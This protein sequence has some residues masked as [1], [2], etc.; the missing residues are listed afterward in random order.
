M[1]TFGLADILGSDEAKTASRHIDVVELWSGCFSVG[2]AALARG[3]TA[4]PFDKYRIP[5]TT[6]VEGEFCE[7]LV[8][9]SGFSKAVSTVLAVRPNGLLVMA[10]TCSSFGFPNSS[11][12]KRTHDNPWGDM[13]YDKVQQGNKEFQA[14]ERLT[15]LGIARGLFVVLENPPRSWLWTL[16][17]PAL[18]G[19]E[20]SEVTVHRCAYDD[21]APGERFY[22]PY[23]FLAVSTQAVEKIQ[24]LCGRCTCPSVL[25]NGHLQK[26]I[27]LMPDP[28]NAK[29]KKCGRPDRLGAAAAYPPRLGEA[30]L[31]AWLDRPSSA[32]QASQMSQV[33][34]VS[35]CRVSASQ[36][37]EA[38]QVSRRRVSEASQ[39][40]PVSEVDDVSEE[41]ECPPSDSGDAA[42]AIEPASEPSIDGSA[43]EGPFEP[44]AEAV[45]D[46]SN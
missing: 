35:R 3:F 1:A 24:H 7:D 33:S 45:D 18:D 9:Q 26:H 36:V 12:C 23:K 37:S 5:G 8:T 25:R 27:R 32:L 31:L 20:V 16:M 6:D 38:S 4:V 14:C 10:P 46:D 2:R 21:T 13:S 42:D 29:G 41:S 30:L 11:R 44:P 19:Y 34:L 17:N 28:D 39:V 43:D 22:K 15:L 40:S